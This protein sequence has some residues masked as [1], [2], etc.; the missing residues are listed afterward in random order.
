MSPTPAPLPS[1]SD[2]LS[3][4]LIAR[5]RRDLSALF[6]IERGRLLVAVSGGGDSL[7]LMLLARAALGDRCLA[8]TVDHGLRAASASEAAFVAGLAAARGIAHRALRGELPARAGRTA[9]LSARARA[10]RYVLLEAERVR[11]GADAIATA[12]HA[13]DQLETMVMRLNRGAGVAGL[14]GVRAKGGR[15]VR[16]LLGWRRAELAAIV[17]DAGIVPVEDPTNVDERYDRARLRKVLSSMDAFD[18]GHW[19]A[20]ARALGDAEDAIGWS[21]ERLAGERIAAVEGRIEL[22]A[23]DL[24]FELQRRLVERCLRAVEP[25]IN[26]RGEALA[27]LA[28]LLRCGRSGMLGN[29]RAAVARRG[30][31]TLWTFVQAPARRSH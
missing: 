12:H 15:I 9:N 19:A 20:S 28:A 3:P 29:V 21:V 7:A 11:V 8:A 23:D 25:S 31:R 22:V 14:A 6:D 5:F 30:G 1:A 10:L 13:D 4:A 2:A 16:P 24:P 27:L 18:T 26:P 17:A